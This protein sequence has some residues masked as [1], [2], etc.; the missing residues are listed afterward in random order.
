MSKESYL[1]QLM[2]TMTPEKKASAKNDW[3]AFYVGR[4]MSYLLTVP[5]L[6]ANIEPNVVSLISLLEVII[7]GLCVSTAPTREVAILG[8]LL[9]FLWNLLDG[10]DGNIARLKHMHSQLGSTWDATSGYA[11]MF[12]TFFSM[13]CYAGRESSVW[14]VLGSL[15]AMFTLFPR[16]VMHKAKSEGISNAGSLANKA[17]YGFFRILALNMTSTTGLIQ[18]FMLVAVLF[19]WETIFTSAYFVLNFLIMIISMYKIFKGSLSKNVR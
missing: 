13:G 16:L 3:F 14:I 12:L 18:P 1:E 8:V 2:A 5:F 6:K 9:F 7:A 10:V 4:P 19:K 17:Q 15:S 11:A